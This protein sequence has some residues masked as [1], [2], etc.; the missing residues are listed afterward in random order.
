MRVLALVSGGKD[1]CYAMMKCVEHGHVVVAIANL[2]PPSED[3]SELDSYM[4]QTIG[5]DLVPALAEALDLP[6]FRAPITGAA[7]DQGLHYARIDGDEVE[8]LYRLL[9][10]ARSEVPFDAVCSGAILSNYQRTRVED[11]CSRLGLDSLAYLWQREQGPLLSEM[12]AAGVEAV[13][14]KV[15]SLG[16]GAGQL[17]RTIGSLEPMF[18]K[19]HARFGF[20]QCG[21][22]GEYETFTLDCPLFSRRLELRGARHIEHVADSSGMAPV[23]LLAADGAELVDKEAVDGRAP[24]RQADGA[25]WAVGRRAA[26]AD[27]EEEALGEARAAEAEAAGELAAAGEWAEG[28]APEAPEGVQWRS[29]SSTEEDA[30]SGGLSGWLRVASAGACVL[31]F[32]PRSAAAATRGGSLD[33]E[34]AAV[35][36]LRAAFSS[37]PAALAAADL[38]PSH[39][40]YVRLYVSDMA[41]YGAV[42]AA[43]AEVM[44]EAPAARACVQLPLVGGAHVALEVLAASAPKRHLHVS[45]MSE[46]APRMVRPPPRRRGR[47]T[48]SA[49]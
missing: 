36:Q 38:A 17:N 30:D 37:L 44:K 2:H 41:H 25:W 39:L 40:L 12:T 49:R 16:L 3:V 24:G 33:A 13:L 6:L 48:R 21:E 32:G 18:A 35:A 27:A 14:V 31:A 46:W 23:V 28:A 19:L 15:A 29:T 43:Y 5:S 26:E 9:E 45:S 1:S 20:H 4:Y 34:A 22:G 42:N 47:A 11:V 7:V 10:R 8:D